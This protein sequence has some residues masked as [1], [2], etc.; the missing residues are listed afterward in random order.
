MLGSV[1]ADE[2]QKD[3][4]KASAVGVAPNWVISVPVWGK[5]CTDAFI[6]AVLPAIKAALGERQPTFVVHTDQPSVMVSALA[7]FPH[8]IKRVPLGR[9]AHQSFG[10][11]SREALALAPVNSYVA[12]I[13][14][15]MVPSCEVFAAAER[16]FEVGK[17]V[18]MMAATRTIGGI[19]PA[20]ATARDLL[21]WTMEHKHP[22][23]VECFW[24]TG[25]TTIPWAVYFKR[26][27]DIV[28]HGFHLHPFAVVKSN[29]KVAFK[30][31]TIDTDLI[32]QFRLEEIHLVTDAD[33]AAFAEMSP[34]ERVFRL[35][36]LPFSIN[37]VVEWARLRTTSL[38]RWMFSQPIT[39]V[40]SGDAG[41]LP[42][43]DTIL[44]KLEV[45]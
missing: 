30:G 32:E 1:D 25:R 16:R 2:I 39:V 10:S 33:E 41:Q 34:P 35:M 15:D 20:G 6:G 8:E 38:Q 28:V 7:R 11:A 40:G 3:G 36:S 17:R 31:L 4:A 22:A 5:R 12:F 23:V 42:T 14:A 45:R 13:N 27:D 43:C 29:P 37:N 9:S 19:P 18:I 24:G 21:T 44:K 26:G